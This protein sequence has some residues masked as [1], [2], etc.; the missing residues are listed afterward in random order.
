MAV[1]SH[2][3]RQLQPLFAIYPSD[4]IYR[5]PLLCQ[6]ADHRLSMHDWLGKVPYRV[7]ALPKRVLR[8][9][10]CPADLVAYDE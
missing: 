8:N 10:N 6:L 5:E 1:V 4:R 3:G 9:V 2:D 7:L